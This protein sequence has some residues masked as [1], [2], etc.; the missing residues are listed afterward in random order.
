VPAGA[1]APAAGLADLVDR[2]RVD[3]L[4]VPPPSAGWPSVDPELS[5]DGAPAEPVAASVPPDPAWSAAG[6]DFFAAELDRR[7]AVVV[8]TGAACSPPPPPLAEACEPVEAD[9]SA[10][11]AGA[12][13]PPWPADSERGAEAADPA[14]AAGSPAA[15]AAGGAAAGG[16]AGRVTARRARRS[17]PWPWPPSCSPA[18]PGPFADSLLSRSIS[19]IRAIS[20]V[21]LPGAADLIGSFRAARELSI[22]AHWSGSRRVGVPRVQARCQY[23]SLCSTPPLWL[24]CVRRGTC[25]SWAGRRRSGLMAGQA[26]H[27]ARLRRTSVCGGS[28]TA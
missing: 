25:P 7:R 8:L 15:G 24:G 10:G 16:P 28:I 19:S 12:A 13:W 23:L 27:R 26:G 9:P 21:R 17:K 18:P 5:A 14:E 6:A 3:R 2:A 4:R 20:P 1:S 11:P 22:R